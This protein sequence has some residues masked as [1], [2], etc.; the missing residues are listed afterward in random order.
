[1]FSPT[2]VQLTND[3]G[4]PSRAL[5]KTPKPI[6]RLIQGFGLQLCPSSLP[7]YEAKA[8]GS[9]SEAGNG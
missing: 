6:N 9:G 5:N 1:M 4:P 2:T 8:I 3:P 7:R